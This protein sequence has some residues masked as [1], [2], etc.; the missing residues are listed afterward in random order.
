[1]AH[2]D[3][4]HRKFG[5][6]YSVSDLIKGYRQL[7]SMT[8]GLVIGWC[9]IPL[10]VLDLNDISRISALIVDMELQISAKGTEKHKDQVK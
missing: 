8:C 3:F 9:P 4:R 10:L 6:Y 2:I 7:I 5:T 1:M